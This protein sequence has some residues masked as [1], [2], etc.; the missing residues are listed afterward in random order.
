MV[1]LVATVSV[2]EIFDLLPGDVED[3]AIVIG[4]KPDESLPRARRLS[5]WPNDYVIGKYDGKDNVDWDHGKYSNAP[6]W[7]KIGIIVHI[8][9]VFYCL[10][11]L[12]T[13]CDIYF[14]G[15]LD[16]M[17]E[18]WGINEDVAGA[19]FMAA[20][21]SAPEL[22]TSIIGAIVE[23]DVGFGT[24]VGSAVFNVLAVIGCCGL[25]A[26]KPIQLTW[27][28]LFRDCTYYIFGLALLAAFAS[29]PI[30]DDASGNKIGGGTISLW[31]AILLFAAYIGYCI[32]MYFSETLER[33][34]KG[35]LGQKSG[36]VTQVQPL[37]E[38]EKIKDPDAVS[39]LRA[40]AAEVDSTADSSAADP[41]K[42]GKEEP[43]T[44]VKKP[45][46]EHK[47]SHRDHSMDRHYRRAEHHAHHHHHHYH[48][49][50]EHKQE[51]IDNLSI[52][53]DLDDIEELLKV[54]DRSDMSEF[55]QW[56]ICSPVYV[57]LYY[58]IPRPDTKDRCL[59]G[60]KNDPDKS[61]MYMLPCFGMALLWIAFYSYW[62]VYC[63][64]IFGEAI[65]GGGDNVRI[66]LGFTLLAAGTSIPD[67]VSSVK[68][69]SD[70][71]GD[72][73]VSSSIGSNIFDIL[74]GLPI[75]WILK[76][77]I[78]EMGVNGNS[79][80]E[81]PIESP[82]I[83]IYVFLLLFMVFLVILSII[84]LK[85]QLSKT[86]GACM[87]GLYFVFLGIVLPVE[88]IDKGPYIF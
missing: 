48:A 24:I 33:M 83:P 66:V 60:N 30:K 81:V 20:G 21:G 6:A 58:G 77:G 41:V 25:A 54:P 12:N 39:D 73:A 84:L 68:V 76:I 50:D 62:L 29:G 51:S 55:L 32:L 63:V 87:A 80:Y 2:L 56:A 59:F 75:P 17:V 47:S 38:P 61:T 85:W 69:A 86:L 53:S 78:I 57:S 79:D 70:G 4:K 46:D 23:T 88:L 34:V 40:T 28:P 31:K 74:V 5:F 8:I 44:L 15:A 37:S 67:M 3:T 65:L 11:G 16:E 72:M 64:E 9:V 22:F 27:W 35:C 45:A 82:Y 49:H 14:C 52:E 43:T 19:T 36:S 1:V 71:K 10:V 7:R 42:L 18:S 26:E 13:V